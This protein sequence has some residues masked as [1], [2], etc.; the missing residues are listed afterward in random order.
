[1]T[2]KIQTSSF[3]PSKKLLLVT[4]LRF[5]F[6]PFK[7]LADGAVPGCGR[8]IM[9]H[10]KYH[11]G[12][13]SLAR[14]FPAVHSSTLD[15]NLSSTQRR[16]LAIVQDHFDSTLQKHYHSPDFGSGASSAHS[17]ERNQLFYTR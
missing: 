5:I 1:M 15:C 8:L 7:L 13:L 4:P 10:E 14:V 9:L 2:A 17:V 11:S 16:H 6:F 3:P 12:P